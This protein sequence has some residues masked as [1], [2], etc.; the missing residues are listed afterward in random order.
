MRGVVGEWTGIMYI[1]NSIGTRILG[2]LFM[3]WTSCLGPFE[4]TKEDKKQQHNNQTGEV[5]GWGG[6]RMD[7]DH[8]HDP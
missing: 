2:F 5:N 1:S 8:V 6:G 4:R 7:R 3:P